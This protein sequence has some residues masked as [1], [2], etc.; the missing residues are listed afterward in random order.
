MIQGI[1]HTNISMIPANTLCQRKDQ[2][3]AIKKK[4]TVQNIVHRNGVNMISI[5]NGGIDYDGNVPELLGDVGTIIYAMREELYFQ[6]DVKN[7][8]QFL[9]DYSNLILG[10]LATPVGVR[11]G[12]NAANVVYMNVKAAE[13][14]NP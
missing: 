4:I 14:L 13:K 2:K 11:G 8:E 6:M 7:R 12:L 3:K 9:K 5:E 1:S 10:I